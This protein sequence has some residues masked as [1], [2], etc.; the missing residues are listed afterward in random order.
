MQ[1]GECC[2]HPHGHF[3]SADGQM[4]V[5]PNE[6]AEATALYDFT[7]GLAKPAP[8]GHSPIATGMMPDSSKYYVANFLDQHIK[9]DWHYAASWARSYN[10]K[11]I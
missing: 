9:R 4:M 1:T 5:T 7:Y 10:K 11:V 2:A 8:T 6:D 3:M